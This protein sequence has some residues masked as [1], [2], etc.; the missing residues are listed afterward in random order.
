MIHR[1]LHAILPSNAESCRDC[2]MPV[3]RA[4]C[5]RRPSRTPILHPWVAKS[6]ASSTI[7]TSMMPIPSCF[8]K[9]SSPASLPTPSPPSWRPSSITLAPSIPPKLEPSP[10]I[11]ITY[12]LACLLKMLN[13]TLIWC[14]PLPSLA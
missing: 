3:S 4:E 10:S 7:S 14:K 5:L 11:C 13:V 12:R 9:R 8:P 1:P 2:L 6:F